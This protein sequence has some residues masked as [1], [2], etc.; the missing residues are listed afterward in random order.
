MQRGPTYFIFHSNNKCKSLVQFSNSPYH[1]SLCPIHFAER[2]GLLVYYLASCMVRFLTDPYSQQMESVIK[3][4]KNI[5]KKNIAKNGEG[6]LPISL[7]F[8]ST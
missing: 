1:P 4:I 3:K 7:V 6:E 5:T 8:E 2:I